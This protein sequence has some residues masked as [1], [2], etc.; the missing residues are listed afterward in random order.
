[1]LDFSIIASPED[2]NRLAEVYSMYKDF[3]VKIALRKG[4]NEYDAEETVEK[5]FLQIA[6]GYAQV[7][8]KIGAIDSPSTKSYLLLILKSKIADHW[9][10][11]DEFIQRYE[12]ISNIEIESSVSPDDAVEGYDFVQ[13]IKNLVEDL[14][15]ET[16][17]ILNLNI[18]NGLTPGE[19][20]KSLRKK[21]NTISKTILWTKKEIQRQCLEK[22]YQY[23][24]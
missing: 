12:D 11:Q 9:K 17:L 2:R 10:Q 6:E 4:L 19:I 22:G 14:P 24:R 21:P 15:Y 16:R 18:I 7:C 23:V 20:A 13:Q 3:L 8:D 1:M 5:V